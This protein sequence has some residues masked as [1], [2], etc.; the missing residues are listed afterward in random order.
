M[1]NT[2]DKCAVCDDPAST[3]GNQILYCDGKLTNGESKHGKKKQRQK[4]KVLILILTL[5]KHFRL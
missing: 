1:C 5:F 4:I 2:Q 3:S